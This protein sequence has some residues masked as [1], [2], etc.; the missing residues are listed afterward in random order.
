MGL[1]AM[2][3]EVA[4]SIGVREFLVVWAQMDA[5]RTQRPDFSLY[6]PK[7]GAWERQERNRLIL[8]YADAGMSAG[9]IRQALAKARGITLTQRHI[10][11][12]IN[13]ERSRTRPTTHE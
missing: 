11:R 9:T 12:V 3:L 13:R 8:D 10:Q 5:A 1:S 6:L 2:W 4:E 7:Y